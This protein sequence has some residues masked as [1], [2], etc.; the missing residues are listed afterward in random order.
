MNNSKGKKIFFILYVILACADFLYSIINQIRHLFYTEFS[1]SMLFPSLGKRILYL[2]PLIAF[3]ILSKKVAEIEDSQKIMKIKKILII[4]LCSCLIFGAVNYLLKVPFFISCLFYTN[5]W[6]FY[7]IY[8]IAYNQLYLIFSLV[9]DICF[10]VISILFIK[11]LGK[12]KD[13][14]AEFMEGMGKT[15]TGFK[16]GIANII[17]LS[18]QTV[19]NIIIALAMHDNMSGVSGEQAMGAAFV[20]LILIVFKVFLDLILLPAIPLSI[21][22]IVKCNSKKEIEQDRKNRLLGKRINIA[23]LVI[24]V[25]ELVLIW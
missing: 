5:S 10:F 25:A 8:I 14:Y 4:Y 17:I 12:R 18:I 20:A 15:S 3:I 19:L 1:F 9:L 11:N 6:L 24:A 22:G 23:C 21:A 16:L 7:L 13:S 2:L